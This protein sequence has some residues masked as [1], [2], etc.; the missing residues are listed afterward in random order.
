MS[1]KALRSILA[2]DL[3]QLELVSDPQ[4]SPDGKSVVFVQQRVD[5]KSEKKYSNLWVASVADGTLRQFTYGDQVD[6]YPR[7]SPDGRTIAFVSNRNYS[8]QKQ[9]YLLPFDGGE[10][11]PLTAFEGALASYT[12]SP[13]GTRLACVFRKKDA[14]VI[15]REA[16][17]IKQEL[18]V[19]ARHITRMDYK[20]DG[21]GFT[22]TER[23]H[24][25]LVD[26]QSGEATQLTDSD[27]HDEAQP[28]WSPDGQSLIFVSNRS[29][30]PDR[31]WDADDFFIISASGGEPRK[32]ETPFGRKTDPIFSPDG[33]WIAYF[34][35]GDRTE[36]WLQPNLWLISVDG[37]APPRNLTE[38]HDLDITNFTLNDTC[39]SA[40]LAPTWANDSQ[41]VYFQASANGST[42]LQNIA[43]SD[44]ELTG[45]ITSVGAVVEFS[46][47]A[48]QSKVAT[49]FAQIDEPGQILIQDVGSAETKALTTVNQALFDQID[50]GQIEEVWFENAEGQNLQGWILKPPGFDPDQKHP[51][52]LEIHGGPMG[53]YGHAFMHEFYYLA[54]QGYVV[55]YTNPRGGR[56]YGQAHT[57]AIANDWGTADYADVIAWTDKVVELPYIDET[58]L[59]VTGGSYGG[60]MTNWTISHT[61]R[62]KA[63]V[64]QRCVS[65][66]ISM[67]GSSDLHTRWQ[68]LFGAEAPPWED[69]ENYWRQSPLKYFSQVKTPTLVIH[70]EQDLRCN[71]E[72]GEQIFIALKVLGVDT[73]M[74]RF[75]EEAHGLSRGGRT[76]RR[77]A[78][79]EHIA[80]WF[81]RYLK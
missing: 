51:A 71:I 30:E 28:C 63:A 17:E 29:P 70:S 66:F 41:S 56:G 27:I 9:I 65:N 53:Q 38:A 39:G 44:S 80:R 58:R 46:F 77:I 37:T 2:E 57:K 18:G 1:N 61:D 45:I 40:T 13:D 21:A 59:G 11:R 20:A 7:W 32:L 26:V 60:Y 25:W 54:A 62:F 14:E 50:L 31:D 67:F 12:W 33:Q 49:L 55:F 6:S 22:P 42:T 72:Q 3:Y 35:E 81:N 74:V 15:E 36:L 16:D 73:E 64:S 68:S 43:V 10:A 52:I 48:A 8:K 79:L 19:V 34:H 23:W 47:D 76:D 4:L 24:L 69:L 75:P 5:Q 78:R